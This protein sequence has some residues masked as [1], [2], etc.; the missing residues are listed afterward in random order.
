LEDWG[1]L[2]RQE[3]KPFAQIRGPLADDAEHFLLALA[4][5]LRSHRLRHQSDQAL[6]NVAYLHIAA[7]RLTSFAPAAAKL[8]SDRWM[9]I[10]ALA[11]AAIAR[12]RHDI[13]RQVFTAADRPRLQRDYLQERCIELTGTPPTATPA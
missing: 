6:E 2:H 11:Q 12:D 3:T 9:P 1:L 8:G 4:D 13:A 10:V 7:G 5:E